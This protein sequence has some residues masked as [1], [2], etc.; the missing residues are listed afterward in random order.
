MVTADPSHEPAIILRGG[1]HSQGTAAPNELEAQTQ[2]GILLR[3]SI[4]DPKPRQIE[5]FPTQLRR[6]QAT[7][8]KLA[9]RPQNWD[10]QGAAEIKIETVAHAT[11]TLWDLA[12]RAAEH[13][14]E[15]PAPAVGVSPDGAVG[16]EWS[17]PEVYLA[18]EC[19]DGSRSVYVRSPERETERFVRS[20]NDLWNVVGPALERMTAA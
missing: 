10:G 2:P 7:L 11:Q 18:V 16:F 8:W 1:L 14:R 5:L 12:W 6:A 19:L 3:V 17:T 4:R 9:G 13:D 20:T 15:L